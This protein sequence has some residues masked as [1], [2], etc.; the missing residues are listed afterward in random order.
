MIALIDGEHQPAVVRAA[1]RRLASSDEVV[2][3][4]FCGGGEKAGPEALADLEGTYGVPV[5]R[6]ADR[7][8]ALRAVAARSDAT[9]VVDLADEPVVDA[10]GKLELAALAL[11]LGLAFRGPG[12]E[13]RP[14]PSEPLDYPGPT[15]AVIGTSKRS[16]KTALTCGLAELLAAALAEAG[17]RPPVVVSMGRGGPP[18]P[19]LAR[20]GELD[21][22]RLVALSRAGRHAASDY[23]EDALLGGIDA[24]G[25][26]RAGGGLAGEAY[27]TNLS[28][29]AALAA[30]LDPGAILF[31]GSGAL[32]P[33]V[34]C[35]RSLCVAPA[36]GFRE[37]ALG[38]LGPLRLQRADLVAITG[39]GGLAP[40]ERRELVGA[41]GRW[42]GAPVAFCELRPEPATQ[43]EPGRRCAVFSTA[44]A[45]AEPEL[46]AAFERQGI[47]VGLLS[48]NLARREALTDDLA[49][50]RRAGC[51]TYLTEL[52]AAAID[53]VAE[54][55][56]RDGAPVAFLRNRPV[57]L[58]GSPD[59]DEELR[60]LVSEALATSEVGA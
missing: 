54:A 9:A 50:A 58:A 25:C 43:V 52:K 14:P 30:E 28:A 11:G 6:A 42:T 16:G 32:I 31:E 35:R 20:A 44:P 10:A 57:A 53:Q 7:L 29:A 4:V 56:L 27:E 41:V 19:E 12:L 51:E 49:E 46:R 5:E 26:R 23:L 15:L 55:A 33:P 48:L 18:E 59:L 38:H 37:Q 39:A 13:L 47:E 21:L 36:V 22:D 17:E 60:L 2:G 1:L 3:A 8:D 40:S 45:A 34:E 24:I